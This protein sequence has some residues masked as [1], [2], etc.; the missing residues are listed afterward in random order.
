VARGPF[1]MNSESEIER[2][3]AEYQDGK[4]GSM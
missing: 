1:V 3:Y 2:A 4:F